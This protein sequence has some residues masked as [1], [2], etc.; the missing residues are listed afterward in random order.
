MATAA[1][2]RVAVAEDVELEDEKAGGDAGVG[3]RATVV[4]VELAGDARAERS[5]RALLSAMASIAAC[6]AARVAARSGCR[7]CVSQL[8]TKQS[9]ICAAVSKRKEWRSEA[10]S[11]SSVRTELGKP[12]VVKSSTGSFGRGRLGSG[13]SGQGLTPGMAISSPCCRPGAPVSS[14]LRFSGSFI[15]FK[16]VTAAVVIIGRAGRDRFWRVVVGANTRRRTSALAMW[17]LIEYIA[18]WC[19]ALQLRARDVPLEKAKARQWRVSARC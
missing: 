4:A 18:D 19:T 8:S 16:S 5:E 15:A 6:R 2:G 17:L 11:E 1:T 7:S 14:L 13:Y 3:E 9:P 10:M 12:Q